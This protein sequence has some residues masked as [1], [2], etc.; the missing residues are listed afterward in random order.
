MDKMRQAPSQKCLHRPAHGQVSHLETMLEAAE[1]YEW[2]VTYSYDA[3]KD[4]AVPAPIKSR[5]GTEDVP[6]LKARLQEAHTWVTAVNVA[7]K[8]KPTLEALEALLAWDPPPVHHA[9]ASVHLIS[10]TAQPE[11]IL[12]YQHYIEQKMLQ[13]SPL[14]Q[15][16]ASPW[17]SSLIS[18]QRQSAEVHR[19]RVTCVSMCVF[20]QRSGGSEKRPSR[21]RLG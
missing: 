21:D 1:A 20:V 11:Q 18:P 7:V 14:Q 16:F 15:H 4:P 6:A 19:V 13:Q 8:T 2:G 3:I 10:S 12:R 5:A 17:V 9:G